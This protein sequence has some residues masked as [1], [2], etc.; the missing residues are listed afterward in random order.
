MTQ[1]ELQ[2]EDGLQPAITTGPNRDHHRAHTG[3]RVGPDYKAQ[4]QGGPGPKGNLRSQA[5]GCH[6]NSQ[7]Q[8]QQQWWQQP[9]RV[10]LCLLAPCLLLAP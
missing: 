1:E 3:P 4:G 7:Q 6:L 9:A 2:A 10:L 5:R 8:Q